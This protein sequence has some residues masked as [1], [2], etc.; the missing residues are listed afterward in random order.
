V[1]IFGD[2]DFGRPLVGASPF[3]FLQA[4]DSLSIC[5]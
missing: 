1:E 5:V 2:S 3:E 4:V